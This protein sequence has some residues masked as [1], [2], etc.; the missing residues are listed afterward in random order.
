[1]EKSFFLNPHLAL[2]KII[3]RVS[4]DKKPNHHQ[5]LRRSTHGESVQFVTISTSIN[6]ILTKIFSEKA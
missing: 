1:M 6:S 2:R 5:T 4:L 3:Q